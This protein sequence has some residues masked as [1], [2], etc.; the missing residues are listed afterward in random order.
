MH[1]ATK[2]LSDE[3][4]EKKSIVKLP[5]KVHVRSE[6]PYP[7]TKQFFAGPGLEDSEMEVVGHVTKKKKRSESKKKRKKRKRHV[8]EDKTAGQ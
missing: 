3:K 2:T 4:G 5:Q 8:N 1:H 7:H 6:A